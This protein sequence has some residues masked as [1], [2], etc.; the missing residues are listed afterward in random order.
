LVFQIS[1][2]EKGIKAKVLRG[3]IT[4]VCCIPFAIRNLFKGGQFSL[5]LNM[6]EV[7]LV[8]NDVKTGKSYQKVISDD[9]LEGKKIG[10][11]ISGD[12]VG[13]PGYELQV[14]GGSDN[15]GFP[16]RWD[17]DGTARKKALLTGGP[18]VHL[19][20][21]GMRVRKSVRGNVVGKTIV[22]VN[23][24]V[25]KYGSKSV[26]DLLGL[27]AE[28]PAEEAPKEEAPKEE[29]PKEEAPKEEA[30]KEEAPKEEAP[31]EEAPAKEKT[32]EKKE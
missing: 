25:T 12:S 5:G 3:A 18:G 11:M 22:Q 21:R 26:E 17:I 16:M 32:E 7:K 2:L 8:I 30:P 4:F 1:K 6:T 10:D 23:L 20:R 14:R 31:K 27:K 24:K 13:L 15:A 9:A 28:A 29:A 19:D